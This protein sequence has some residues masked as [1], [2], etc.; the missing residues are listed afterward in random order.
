MAARGLE[1]KAEQET[2]ALKKLQAAAGLCERKEV[3][4]LDWMYEQTSGAATKDDDELMNM[5]VDSG[6]SKDIEDVKNLDTSTAGSLFLKSA[7]KTTEDMLRKLRE[8]PLFQIKRQEQAA[9][10][11]MMANPLIMAKIKR[12]Q[13]KEAKKMDKKAKKAMKKEKKAMKKAA[14]AA[15][16]KIKKSKSSSDDSSASDAPAA[17]VPAA[18]SRRPPDTRGQK[19]EASPDLAK[20]GPNSSQI[21]AR[22]ERAQRIAQ[23]KE[24]ALASRGL[25]RK[26]TEEEKN[27]RVEMMRV[28]AQKHE[29][30]KDRRIDR[31]LQKDKEIEEMEE[32]MRKSS[33]QKYFRDMRK[34]AYGG[35]DMDASLSDRLKSQRHRRQ[36]NLNDTLEKD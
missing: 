2:D 21:S 27:E 7:T 20:L 6:K 13:E 1:L 25:G 16:G 18:A 32:K 33:D 5:A 3:E 35:G 24:A 19:R 31:A 9:R 30:H 17:P 23:Q 22:E 12:K 11:D 4:R 15:G 14:K 29:R 36:K 8:D 28:D 10:S 26:L 34:D